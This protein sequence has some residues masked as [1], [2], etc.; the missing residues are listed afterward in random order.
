MGVT[1]MAGEE[2]H[3][4]GED[5]LQRAKQWLDFTTRVYRTWTARDR[6]QGRL[7]HFEWPHATGLEKP[8]SFDLGGSFQGADLEGQSFLAEV[9]NY[10]SEMD[11]PIQ[12]RHFLA[13]CY[14]ALST[15]PDLCD[16]FLWISWSPFQAQKWDQHATTANV[17]KALTHKDNLTR[18]FGVDTA[19]RVMGLLDRALAAEV[20]RRV[21]LVTLG[22]EQEQ[23]V[24]TAEHSY[25]FASI[26]A[27]E[28]GPRR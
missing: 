6:I 23:L 26:I 14:V 17:V 13:K 5:G 11:L 19:D 21:W 15:E 24:L 27:R 3:A 20:A 9:K 8:F 2:A 10:K 12:F 1:A 18:V 4:T 25:Q 7:C 16:N 22:A 28:R